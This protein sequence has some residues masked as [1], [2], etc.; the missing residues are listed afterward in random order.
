M[1]SCPQA[2]WRYGKFIQAPR[3]R[4]YPASV[5]WQLAFAGGAESLP[6]PPSYKPRWF[7]FPCRREALQVGG[8]RI[9]PI[10][11]PANNQQQNQ[12]TI[13]GIVVSNSTYLLGIV[14]MYVCNGLRGKK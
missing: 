6:G 14:T 9:K 12:C 3:Y 4:V 13:G 8:P 7:E 1:F 11:D 2:P 5:F 10:P